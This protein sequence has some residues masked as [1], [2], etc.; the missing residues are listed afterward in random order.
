MKREAMYLLNNKYS[1][2]LDD[3][4]DDNNDKNLVQ[5]G[6]ITRKHQGNLTSL[7]PKSLPSIGLQNALL[8]P[9]VVNSRITP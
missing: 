4:D 9:L 3:S 5:L 8:S 2:R 1:L 6:H 7:L